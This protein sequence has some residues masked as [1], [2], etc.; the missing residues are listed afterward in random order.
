[1]N[2]F[3]ILAYATRRTWEEWLSVIMISCLWLVA[4]VLV[5]PGPSATAA[6]FAAARDTYDGTYWNANDV[7]YHF[8]RAFGPAW[9][10][11]ALNVVVVGLSLFNL[12]TFWSAPGVWAWLR[13]VWLAGLGVWLG[14]NLFYWP[15]WHAA[16][17]HS[18]RN[19][20]A[21][22]G[23]FWLRH[24]ATAMTLYAILLPLAAV[25]L[26]FALP[27]ALGLPFWIALVAETAVRRSLGKSTDYTDFTD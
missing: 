14:L 10:W 9:K 27:V 25:A 17:D 7:W 11:G 20:Y 21:N 5:V 8:K 15:F 2:P 19:T 4:Q 13:W 24:P 22:C 18:V 6:L 12:S 3:A 23:R 26:P 1:M 16:D